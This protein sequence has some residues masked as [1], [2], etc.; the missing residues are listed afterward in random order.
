M[1]LSPKVGLSAHRVGVGVVGHCHLPAGLAT[2]A[3]TNERAIIQVHT[4]VA[5]DTVLP[6]QGMV[7]IRLSGFR[8]VYREAAVELVSYL[9]E[10]LKEP[11]FDDVPVARVYGED[12]LFELLQFP[13]AIPEPRVEGGDTQSSKDSFNGFYPCFC[14]RSRCACVC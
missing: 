11:F 5:K 3:T 10:E 1:L 9:L 6:P 4:E 14:G 2:I 8:V 7:A 13:G 12:V